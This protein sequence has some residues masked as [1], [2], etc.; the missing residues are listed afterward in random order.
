M[1]KM[2]PD[3]VARKRYFVANPRQKGSAFFLGS[4]E[5]AGML[6]N[7]LCDALYVYIGY[8]VDIVRRIRGGQ[9]KTPKRRGT[10]PL[11]LYTLSPHSHFP[12]DFH[13]APCYPDQHE[14][15]GNHDQ[16][17]ETPRPNSPHGQPG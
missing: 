17:K 16:A 12:L 13:P 15:H 9:E 10:P 5:N 1:P 7:T 8:I 2:P 3:N 6:Q 14:Q 11:L 4:V